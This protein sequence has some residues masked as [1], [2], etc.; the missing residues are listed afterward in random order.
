MKHWRHPFGL[1][2]GALILATMW[3]P[4]GVS[5]GTPA[6]PLKKVRFGIGSIFLTTY[7]ANLASNQG[8]F[9]EQGL[10]VELK[11][12]PGTTGL[13][14]LMAGQ[15][16][17]VGIGST[18]IF[19]MAARG[20]TMTSIFAYESKHIHSLSVR[21]SSL[22]QRKV[23]MSDPLDKRLATLK[24]M[25]LAVSGE[26]SA[27]DTTLQM[28][29][30]AAKLAPTDIKKV[31][32]PD[33]PARIAAM[34]AG[35]LDGFIG[36]P[37]ADV[38]AQKDGFSV[39]FIKAAEL[40]EFRDFVPNSVQGMKSWID[41]HPEEARGAARALAKANNFLVNNPN[42][43]AVLRAN[44]FKNVTE[45]VLAESLRQIRDAIPVDGKATRAGWENAMRFALAG[46]LIKQP[47]DMTE[48]VYWTNKY[49]ERP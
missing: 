19:V 23:K 37:H 8:Y 42:A 7:A 2:L 40:A 5:A 46:G 22:D 30:K 4:T 15:L 49:L 38:Q 34:N 31:A 26:G 18:D 3:A 14:A 20:E 39:I 33:Q 41:S 47:I 24:G 13:Q 29:L 21:Q 16:D 12:T 6:A 44:D 17:L 32:I 1:A 43:I 10:D 9:R 45:E 27:T 25:T 36:A 48:G 35:Q 28:M 11:I